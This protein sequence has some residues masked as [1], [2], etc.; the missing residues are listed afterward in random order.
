MDVFA[1]RMRSMSAST[2]AFVPTI[3]TPPMPMYRAATYAASA[4]NAVATP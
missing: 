3:Y 1:V 4:D 2:T